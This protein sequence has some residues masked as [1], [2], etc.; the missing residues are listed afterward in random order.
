M[1]V[2]VPLPGAHGNTHQIR[3]FQGQ[4]LFARLLC[5]MT[6]TSLPTIYLLPPPRYPLYQTG[7]PT[8][9]LWL[10]ILV[11]RELCSVRT[12]LAIPKAA[13]PTHPPIKCFVLSLSRHHSAIKIHSGLRWLLAVLERKTTTSWDLV[14]AGK[15]WEV[16]GAWAMPPF[17]FLS[18]LTV[19]K[20]LTHMASPP[21]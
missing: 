12:E 15:L 5:R 3:T 13:P 21:C 19:E 1:I 10:F 18:I 9:L 11:F 6:S 8:L 2:V 14:L 7:L 16:A 17:C 4:P 20:R